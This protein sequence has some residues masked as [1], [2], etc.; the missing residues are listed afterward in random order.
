[1][2]TGLFAPLLDSE[3]LGRLAAEAAHPRR[4][5]VAS[6]L[7][8]S[9]RAL[10]LV[11]LSQ[12]LQRPLLVLTS[13]NSA[14]EELEQ[15][16]AF[17]WEAVRGETVP[18]GAVV[19]LP[20]SEADPYDGNSPHTEI[21]ERRAVALYRLAA[22]APVVLLAT[23]RGLMRRTVA[24]ES[25]LDHTV[26]LS[27]GSDAHFEEIPQVLLAAGFTRQEPVT[28]P[29][30]FS[31]RGG[32]LDVFAPDSDEPYRIEFFGDTVDSIRTFDAESQRSRSR[33]RAVRVPPM[34]EQ[35]D[36]KR[37]LLRWAEAAARRWAEPR[38]LHALR[39]RLDAAER[40]E[41]FPGW[42]YLLPLV[43][44]L[45]GTVFDYLGSPVLVVDEPVDLERAVREFADRLERRYT[46]TIDHCEVALPPESLYLSSDE[47]RAA[48][49]RFPRID[50]RLLGKAANALDEQYDDLPR[51]FLFPMPHNAVEVHLV[52]Q[53]PPR[54]HGRVAQFAEDMREA[55]ESR[56][57]RLVVVPSQGV[58][59][60]IREMLAEYD[61]PSGTGLDAN[62][63]VP[64][65]VAVGTLSSGCRFPELNLTVMVETDL[66]PGAEAHT[67]R[68]PRRVRPTHTAFL[69]DFRDLMAGD[70]VV[71]VD[72]GIGLY[73]GL[74]QLAAGE[75]H[76]G[77]REFMVLKYA[78]EARL[79]VPVERLDL[80]QKYMS[81]E[82]HKAKLDRLGGV[83]WAKTK[84]RASRAMRDMAEEL[85]KLYAERQLVTR[86]PF[87]APGGWHREFDDAFEYELTG[88]QVEAIADIDNDLDA[89]TPMDRLLCG[90]VGY[91]KTE[92]AMRAMF[93]V[94]SD[95]KQV[96]VLAPTTVLAFQHYKTLSQ[97]FAAFPVRVELLSRFRSP[98]EQK[99]VIKALAEGSVDI[100]VGTHRILSKDVQFKDL[101][102]VVV[103]EEQR[104]GVA[105]KERLKKLR[106]RV[107]VLTLTATPI[108][109]TLN[110]SLAGMRDM[111]V[112]E[113]PPRDRLAIQTAVV[114]F[115]EAVIRSAIEQ[116]LARGGQ[117][118]FVHNRVDTIY[119]MVELLRR[120]V[121]GAR[122]GVGHGQMVERELED[123][124]LAFVNHRI[125]VLVCTTIIENGI[126]I[127]LANT[128]IV[129]R[130][131]TFGLA[132]LYQLR[133]RVG[134]SN[135]RAYAYLLIP[136]EAELSSIA[137]RRLS[138]L[139]EFADLGAGFR[140]AAL[141]LELR[142]SG[143]LLGGQQSGHINAV[144]FDLYCKMLE[145][146]V[147]E[148]RGEQI[149]E[150]PAVTIDLGVEVR[151]PD[152]FIADVGQRLRL[153]K[154]ISNANTD[155]EVAALEAEIA[156]R[157]G[158]FGTEVRNL[159]GYAR[160]RLRAMEI[161]VSAVE[162]EGD[163]VAIRF[164]ESTRLSPEKLLA[165][166]EAHDGSSF[167]RGGVL[168]VPHG[169]LEGGEL[170]EA[171]EAMLACLGKAEAEDAGLQRSGRGAST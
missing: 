6:G 145:R 4:V 51:S 167:R 149:E 66:F 103:D 116:E 164:S 97:R 30:E 52:T 34:R 5:S 115:S 35:P 99:T 100:V 53:T 168:V 142:G 17:F 75:G 56:S 79:Y 136:H 83:G 71:H 114:P 118:Y 82:G 139:R 44:P 31:I 57:V 9:S 2:R 49:E 69:S 24:P 163:Q 160:I 109:R 88:D 108:P 23:A 65:V 63:G 93:R 15:D 158:A 128:M 130:A 133:G 165:F 27:I 87:S 16:L 105:H 162:R 121:P 46:E 127:P 29:G 20:D 148:I 141:D 98:K 170:L 147:R 67:V 10:L 101:G 132:Q 1:M 146:A 21:L 41:H 155:R 153:Y 43:E 37:S 106:M 64:V 89:S 137:R 78:D 38:F 12:R 62:G 110:M 154:R 140:I 68:R 107:D 77:L 91:G 81:G 92:V 151:I 18:A 143:N 152:D 94:V 50:M 76:D 125:D 80:V 90:D 45:T 150:T 74:V 129:N 126:D 84:A 138:A 157:F 70:L 112:I 85:L 47:L 135:R 72:H 60:R 40:G 3:Q 42:E 7:V 36:R 55:V 86:P 122:L 169:R 102:I 54:Y 95:G 96:A 39:P 61:V 32:I 11:A 117:V 166:V 73:Q 123:V 19:T 14:L 119:T 33:L 159:L 156:D 124:M 120:L 171:V 8:G 134:R 111:S 22:E 26:E 25:T 113:T 104:F 58:A 48:L 59:E 144:G 161:G 131:D 28:A 13:S